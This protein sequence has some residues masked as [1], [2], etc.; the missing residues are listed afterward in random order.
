MSVCFFNSL[1]NVENS[2][3]LITETFSN[4]SFSGKT[5]LPAE[6]SYLSTFSDDF[7]PRSHF[8][9]GSS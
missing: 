1:T 9:I 6:N 8:M 7:L 4:K 5:S 3:I 2:S